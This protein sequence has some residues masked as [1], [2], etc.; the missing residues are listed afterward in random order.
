MI[1]EY[2]LLKQ[3]L[4]TIFEQNT[5]NLMGEDGWTSLAPKTFFC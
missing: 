1:R 4:P 3:I 2:D 5:R